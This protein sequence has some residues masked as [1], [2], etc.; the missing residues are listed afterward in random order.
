[1]DPVIK[2]GDLIKA[3]PLGS[4]SLK[5]WRKRHFKLRATSLEYYADGSGLDIKGLILFSTV[6]KLDPDVRHSRD[7]VFGLHTVDRTYLFGAESPLARHE[8]TQAI[9]RCLETSRPEDFQTGNYMNHANVT[10]FLEAESAPKPEPVSDASPAV[11]ASSPPPPPYP[12][13][14]A[15]AEAAVAAAA[16]QIAGLALGNVQKGSGSTDDGRATDVADAA[17]A[18]SPG[19]DIDDD[20]RPEFQACAMAWYVA[21]S[22]KQLAMAPGDVFDILDSAAPWWIALNAAGEEG[23][24]PSNYLER[25]GY[26]YDELVVPSMTH[27]SVPSADS[28]AAPS[29]GAVAVAAS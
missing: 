9:L 21:G 1:M 22:P 5:R 18:G 27:P 10:S 16:T 19:V 2:S 25:T 14:M 4:G 8:W 11:A 6:T 28:A 20:R 23:L 13:T 26:I 17:R 3:P 15:E 24:V 29:L 7:H 12:G